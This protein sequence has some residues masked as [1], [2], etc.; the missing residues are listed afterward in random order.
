LKDLLNEPHDLLDLDRFAVPNVIDTPGSLAGCGIQRLGG[1]RRIRLRRPDD[2]PRNRLDDVVDIGEILAHLAV[3]EQLDRPAMHD[4]IMILDRETG[5]AAGGQ[6]AM[7]L[8][9]AFAERDWQVARNSDPN[10]MRLGTGQS[11]ISGK[12][13]GKS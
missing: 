13:T 5:A 1:P 8:T 2:Q 11:L 6:A 3:V 7:P 4:G 12:N 9:R 10:V